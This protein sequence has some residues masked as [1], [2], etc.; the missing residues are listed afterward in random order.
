MLNYIRSILRGRWMLLVWDRTIGDKFT[1]LRNELNAPSNTAV[2]QAAFATLELILKETAC[3]G[4]LVVKRADG[5]K[6]NI[7]L[8]FKLSK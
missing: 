4:K 5:S 3:G 2:M 8:V 7:E 6:A 1:T